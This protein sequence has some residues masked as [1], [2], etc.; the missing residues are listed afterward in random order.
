MIFCHILPMIFWICNICNVSLSS[1]NG[2]LN[3]PNDNLCESV[4]HGAAEV[5]SNVRGFI[6][7]NLQ[8]LGGGTMSPT[9]RWYSPARMGSNAYRA[10]TLMVYQQK[11]RRYEEIMEMSIKKWCLVALLKR[12]LGPI[13]IHTTLVANELVSRWN[14]LELW[15]HIW[16]QNPLWGMKLNI[17]KHI[18]KICRVTYI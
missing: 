1:K 3:I 15:N 9:N 17:Y 4:D 10:S 2:W 13:R 18:T 16:M 14:F 8:Q 6:K 11:L 5:Y 7:Y 12:G